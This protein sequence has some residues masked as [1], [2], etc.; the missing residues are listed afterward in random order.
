VGL[1]T[2]NGLNTNFIFFKKLN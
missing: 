2:D 1:Y